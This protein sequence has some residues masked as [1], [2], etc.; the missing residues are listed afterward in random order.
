MI[1]FPQQYL[2]SGSLDVYIASRTLTTVNITADGYY[3]SIVIEPNLVAHL[4]LPKRLLMSLGREPK[5]ILLKSDADIAVYG[6]NQIKTTTDAFLALPTDIIGNRYLAVGSE[7]STNLGVQYL[8]ILSIIAVK[9]NTTIKIHPKSRLIIGQIGVRQLYHS[10]DEPL[11]IT[12]DSLESFTVR[13]VEDV[14]GS[15][16]E[17]NKPISVIS[18]HEC[19]YVPDP[20]RFCDHLIEQV[21]FICIHIAV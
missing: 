1:G 16:I 9:D 2:S 15:L 18:G 3:E 6:L 12:L 13:T 17:S 20:I 19:A 5:G 8:N 4:S 7:R 10:E 14:T 11:I 21:S